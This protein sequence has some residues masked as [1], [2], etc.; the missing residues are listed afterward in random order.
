MAIFSLGTPAWPKRSMMRR[1]A[2]SA[3]EVQNPEGR[4]YAEGFNDSFAG[5]AHEGGDLRKVAFLPQRL[6]WIHDGAIL[7]AKCRM[8]GVERNRDVRVVRVRN[9]ECRIWFQLTRMPGRL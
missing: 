4:R 5:L 3:T 1:G 7:N 8:Q 6:V 2:I 9:A